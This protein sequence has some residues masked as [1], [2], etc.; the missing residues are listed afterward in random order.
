MRKNKDRYEEQSEISRAGKMGFSEGIGQALNKYLAKQKIIKNPK[1]HG[2]FSEPNIGHGAVA[3]A[4]EGVGAQLLGD[5]ILGQPEEHSFKEEAKRGALG[6]SITGAV[7]GLIDAG[8]RD[9]GSGMAK[10]L[11]K[12]SGKIS[13]RSAAL[14]ILAA[15]T[16]VGSLGG[17]IKGGLNSGVLNYRPEE[18][19][20]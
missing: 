2:L 18:R 3:G 10:Y 5:A 15:G 11:A 17:A 8:T 7:H 1:I 14:A 19:E 13:P 20:E 12:K 16:G 9:Y 6:G 4:A